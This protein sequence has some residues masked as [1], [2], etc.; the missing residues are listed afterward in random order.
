MT[1][2]LV[3]SDVD[4]TLVRKD[5]SL[6]QQVI[7]AVH[8]LRAAEIPFTLISARPVSGV[9]PLIAPLGID[10]PL[11]AFNGGVL[12]RPDGSII[13]QHVVDEEVVRGMFALAAELDVGRWVF[14]DNK[15]Y[16]STSEGLRVERERLASN[17]APILRSDFSDLYARADKVTFVSED[18]DLLAGLAEKAS[19]LFGDRATIGQSQTY[20]LDVTDTLANKGD[21]VAAL[22]REL[23]IDLADIVVLGDMDNDVAMFVRAGLSIAMGQAPDSVKAAADLVSS[24]N[25]ADGV[26]H[27]IDALILPR[28]TP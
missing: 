12:F 27:A 26:A 28:L 21:G 8:R 11:A 25:E 7:A 22:A 24:T 15:W 18:R 6:S 1:I 14:A 9:L 4:G 10:I 17:Q 3:V 16:S 19:A 20:Y 5:K 23:G 13:E 2:R